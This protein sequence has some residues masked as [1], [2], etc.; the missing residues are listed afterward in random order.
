MIT[1]M[2]I[3]LALIAIGLTAKVIFRD[4]P[5]SAISVARNQLF[6]LRD[7][8]FEL[9]KSGQLAFDSQ[10][11]RAARQM[12]NGMIRYAHDLSLTQLMCTWTI[13]TVRKQK[14]PA[15]EWDRAIATLP[16]D[17]KKKVDEI[18]DQAFVTMFRL[19]VTRS[20]LLSALLIAVMVV[21]AV[22]VC[23]MKLAEI[24]V[25][26]KKTRTS[27]A[28]E[29]VYEEVVLHQASG[30]TFQRAVKAEAKRYSFAP[31]MCLQAA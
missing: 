10:G 11:Y 8:L 3:A 12:I 21:R 27:N 31:D 9:G 4:Y 18:I 16:E 17:A 19:L 1:Y 28:V 30:R 25:R 14:M 6:S 2:T 29:E 5:G 26:E 24:F 13:K 15:S 7:E 20:A 22:C 23:A